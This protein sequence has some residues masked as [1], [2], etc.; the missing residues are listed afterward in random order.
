MV[1]SFPRRDGMERRDLLATNGEIFGPQGRAIADYAAPGVRV[2]VVGNPCNTNCLIARENGRD[3]PADRWFAMV[4]LD[5]NRTRAF[6]AERAGVPVTDVKNVAIWGNHS[7]TMFPDYQNAK[8]GRKSAVSAIKDKRWFREEL[9]PTVQQRGAAVIK[10]RGASSA[11]SAAQATI[12]SVR[13][14]IEPT[15]KGDCAAL[16]VASHGEYG[17]PEGL[18]FGFPVRS[19]GES[20]EVIEGF[21]H[22]DFGKE[23]LRITTQELLEERDAVR[24][25]LG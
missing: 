8:I 1:G 23:K 4:R 10:A 5:A 14:V 22:D 16:A 12:D 11:A 24:E 9:V 25:L 3:V 15:R 18:Q 17:V 19:T 20:W 6:L 21:R 2:L 13:S 7:P